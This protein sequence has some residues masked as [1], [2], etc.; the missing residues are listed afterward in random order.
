MSFKH[1]V[2]KSTEELVEELNKL[3]EKYNKVSVIHLDKNY[4]DKISCI[5]EC[6]EIFVPHTTWYGEIDEL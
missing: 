6:D 1:L 3:S 5:A 2:C 4:G